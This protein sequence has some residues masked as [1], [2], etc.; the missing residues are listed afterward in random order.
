MSNIASIGQAVR[1]A[2]ALPDAVQPGLTL[3]QA[4]FSF[5]PIRDLPSM[6]TLAVDVVPISV[7][8]QTISRRTN[9]RDYAYHIGLRRRVDPQ[10]ATTMTALSELAGDVLVWSEGLQITGTS[11][12]RSSLP[13]VAESDDLR[14]RR[15]YF[16][17]VEVVLRAWST[18]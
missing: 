18:R 11:W 3:S 14:E 4:A 6:A 1:D 8:A 13:A 5:L 17:V 2:L 10:D 9:H 12:L 7:E 15:L 16:A